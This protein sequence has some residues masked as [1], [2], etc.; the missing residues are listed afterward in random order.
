[1]AETSTLRGKVAVVTGGSN[2][3]G[4][5]TVR[6]L[7]EEGAAVVVG[8][9]KGEDRARKLIGELP[10]SGHRAVRFVLEDAAIVRRAAEEVRVACGRTDIVVNS[11]GFTRPVPHADLDALDETLFDSVLIANVRGPYSV[12]RAFAPMLKASGDGV[13]V[14]VSSVSAFTASG[15][16]IVYCAAKAALDTM[17]MSLAR[18]LGPEIR[19]LCVS[20]AAVAT[21]FVAGRGRPQLE[22]I[23]A[24][25]PLKRVVEAEDIARAVMAC[26]THLRV[27]TGTRIVTDGGRFLN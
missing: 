21:D 1:V 9:N 14:N 27:A 17:T 6:M 11:A 5:A 7:A 22:K 25:T 19:V 24:G 18:A 26:I 15:S 3:I 16:S 12:I 8:Y 4:A 13:V 23:A 2:G 10:G 20:P